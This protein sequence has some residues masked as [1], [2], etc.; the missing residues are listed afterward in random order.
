VKKYFEKLKSFS[1]YN[2]AGFSITV[3][4]KHVIINNKKVMPFLYH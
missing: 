3:Y 1:Y 2:I 4:G